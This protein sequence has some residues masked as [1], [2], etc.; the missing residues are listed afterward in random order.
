MKKQWFAAALLLLA[1]VSLLNSPAYACGLGKDH[2]DEKVP[3]VEEP[4]G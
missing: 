3:P 2:H 1:I 4:G